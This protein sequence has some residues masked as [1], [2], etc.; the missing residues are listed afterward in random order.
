MVLFL[1]T[2]GVASAGFSGVLER[3]IFCPTTWS[4][5]IWQLTRHED[6]FWLNSFNMAD[7]ASD[8]FEV[9]LAETL[10]SLEGKWT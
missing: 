8:R 9:L 5:Y 1:G 10:R 3:R 4:S 2:R 6:G 7:G